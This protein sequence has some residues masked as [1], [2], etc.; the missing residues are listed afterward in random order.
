MGKVWV[1]IGQVDYE[2]S[3]VIA[4]FSTEEAA[5]KYVLFVKDGPHRFDWVWAEP[6]VVDGGPNETP[7]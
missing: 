4:V 3:E 6:F 7:N 1:V 5:E 2:G